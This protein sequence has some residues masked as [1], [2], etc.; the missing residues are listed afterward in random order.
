MPN[1]MMVM[2]L[3]IIIPV[4]NEEKRLPPTL[5]DILKY[6]KTQKYDWEIVLV[7]DGSNDKTVEIVKKYQK[8]EKGIK[9]IDNKI[10]QGKGAVV[11]QGMLES[12]G[13]WRLFMDADNSTKLKEIG[14]FWPFMQD[15]PVIIGSRYIKGSKIITKQPLSRRILSRLG[16]LLTQIVL[17]PKIKDTQ[18]GF[19]LFSKEFAEKIFSKVT[20]KR[21]SFDLEIFA[22]C[23]SNNIKIKEVPVDWEE[24]KDS[25]LK[26]GRTAIRS[27]SELLKT[28]IKQIKGLYKT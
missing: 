19:K 17:A 20:L 9:L 25:K 1:G 8:K 5:E 26:I 12:T 13:D 27:F 18:C 4:Y 2:Q 24:G 15:Y 23:Y 7:N 10:N 14:R 21:W 28:K 11:K 16:N 22:I 3:S 6:L